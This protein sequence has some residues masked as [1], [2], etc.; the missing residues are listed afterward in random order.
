MRTKTRQLLCTFSSTVQAMAFEQAA[1]ETGL[2]GRLIPVPKEVTAGC[3][4]A[5]KA[6]LTARAAL[7]AL[8]RQQNL[9]A[10]KILELDL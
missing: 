8:L 4:L 7:E 1:Q 10:G 9:S 6:P 3:G 2:P 5:F